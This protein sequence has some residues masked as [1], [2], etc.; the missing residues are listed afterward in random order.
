MLAILAAEGAEAAEHG[1]GYWLP[2]TNELIWASLAFVLVMGLLVWKAGPAIKKAM[3]GRTERIQ[4]EMDASA[5]LRTDA[6]AERD[7]IRDAL[8]NSDQEAERIL[9]EA[10]ATAES[11][12]STIIGRIDGE[13][14]ALRER[15]EA[16][17]GAARRQAQADLTGEVSRIAATAAE[18][19]VEVSLDDATQQSLIESYIA[20]V[21]ST[22]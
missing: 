15:H 1:N 12:R 4:G 10:R 16:E 18:R 7:R 14:A 19:I 2:H 5:K 13:I 8:A 6:E 21:A 9:S 22:N 3:V 20:Q 17:L 11:M